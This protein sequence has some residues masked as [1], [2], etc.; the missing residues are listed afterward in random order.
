LFHS[1]ENCTH[2]NYTANQGGR[3]MSHGVII[4]NM[5]EIII[6]IP[7]QFFFP[8]MLWQQEGHSVCKELGVGLL[9]M[10]WLELCTSYSSSCHHHLHHP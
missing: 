7:V 2:T 4:T 1:T 6:N 10:I 5:Q 3:E 9:V 8:S